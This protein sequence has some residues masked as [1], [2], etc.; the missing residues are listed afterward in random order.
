[1]SETALRNLFCERLRPYGAVHRIE[2][3]IVP[4]YPDLACCF[5]G[6]VHMIEAKY[7]GSLPARPATPI[8][9]EHLTREQVEW[10]EGWAGAA[11]SAWLLLQAGRTCYALVAPKGMRMMYEG[12]MTYEALCREAAWIDS[13]L[14]PLI[15]KVLR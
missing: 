2:N 1:M 13:K 14:T 4:G 11:G 8:R 7:L 12:E 6:A 10:A 5:R 9:L 15:L 3:P